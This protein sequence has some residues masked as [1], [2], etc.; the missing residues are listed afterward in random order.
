MVISVLVSVIFQS[1]SHCE[2]IFFINREGIVLGMGN[3]LL[4]I[5]ATVDKDF[6]D[7]YVSITEETII[8]VFL[9]CSYFTQTFDK[10]LPLNVIKALESKFYKICLN[11]YGISP[12]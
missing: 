6:L 1:F 5:S 4:D 3:P 9:N 10:P 2:L 11:F 7:K 8:F 12:F